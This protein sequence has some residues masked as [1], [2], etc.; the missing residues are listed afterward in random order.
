MT[1]LILLGCPMLAG[2]I[3]LPCFRGVFVNAAT[4]EFPIE[5]DGNRKPIHRVLQ[6]SEESPWPPVVEDEGIIVDYEVDFQAPPVASDPDPQEETIPAAEDEGVIVD[7]GVNFQ[8]PPLV[9]AADPDPE[10][11]TIPVSIVNKKDEEEIVDEDTEN[12]VEQDELDNEDDLGID[13]TDNPIFLD[14]SVKSGEGQQ[15]AEE[16]IE[17]EL[18]NNGLA[19]SDSDEDEY[20]DVNNGIEKLAKEAENN[21]EGEELSQQQ[22]Q[23]QEQQDTTSSSASS[24]SEE[25]PATVPLLTTSSSRSAWVAHGTIG[26]IVF[27]LLVPAAISSALFRDLIPTHWIYI[28]VCVNVVTFA[29]TFFTVGIAFATM[30]GMGGAGE[31]HM[32]EVH[33]IVGLMLLL[34]VSFQTAN[35]FLRPPREFVTGEDNSDNGNSAAL[36]FGSK[37]SVEKVGSVTARGLWYLVHRLSGILIFAFGA[38]QVTSGLGLFAT[39]FGTPDYGSVYIGYIAWLTGVIVVAKV[40]Y[41]VKGRRNAKSMK[42]ANLQLGRRGGGGGSGEGGSIIRGASV[43]IH[44]NLRYDLENDFALAESEYA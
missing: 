13:V 7:E 28:H 41:F 22:T 27:G 17:G 23:E 32:K 36:S 42:D 1:K 18:D 29:M 11:E 4:I 40:Y 16:A 24:K 21:E 8:A 37:L 6:D 3:H 12:F 19:E 9:P 35:G 30:N 10:E 25:Q 20:M 5:K 43:G 34:L 33:H 39:R 2:I 14:P 26:A 44:S 38:Y 31:G 15:A